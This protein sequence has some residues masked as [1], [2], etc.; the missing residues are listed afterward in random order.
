MQAEQYGAQSSNVNAGKVTGAQRL[1]TLWLRA[2]VP[3]PLIAYGKIV[4][5]AD[6][7]QVAL[8]ADAAALSLDRK[9]FN[10]LIRQIEK[11]R[12]LLAQ[13]HE[14]IAAFRQS[15]VQVLLPLRDSLAVLAKQQVLVLDGLLAQPGLTRHL[16]R[17]E[18]RTLT[19]II[20]GTCA[21]LLEIR[22]DEALKAIYDKHGD[23]SFDEEKQQELEVFKA[24]GEQLSGV[25]LGDTADIRSEADLLQRMRER[26]AER[27]EAEAAEPQRRQ[28]PKGKAQLERERELQLA[29]QSVREVYRKLV[30]ALHPDREP[31]PQLQA[32][33]NALLQRVN[34]A[35][36]S[37]DLLTL[38]E[39]QLD[40]EGVH[41]KQSAA[42]SEERLRY[43][44]QILNNQ[45]DSLKS[46]VHTLRSEFCSELGL[47]WGRPEPGDIA[48]IIEKEAVGLRAE[49][50][51]QKKELPK[52]AD[53]AYVK[54][55]LKRKEREA[56]EEEMGFFDED[57]DF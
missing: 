24:L 9:R 19:Q 53:F 41:A 46:E 45:V 42:V 51:R 20:C 50:R 17:Q 35:Y 1:R 18:R 32:Q 6:R 31:D 16:T 4:S 13:W 37:K 3:H 30:S 39:V 56:R 14:Q 2:S 33:K 5:Q 29:T 44:N 21:E 54:R 25:D 52:L 27:P 12:R 7:F 11:E 55:W 48:G 23:M 38:L 57:D 36:E 49:V 40:I 10:R 8:R 15:F 47:M 26:M 34:R 43:Y 22:E 28:R